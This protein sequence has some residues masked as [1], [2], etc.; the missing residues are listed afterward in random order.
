MS[1]TDT[2]RELS[3]GQTVYDADGNELGHIQG[4]DEHG[5]F[6]NVE[7]GIEGYS[8]RH[9]VS[10][11]E[12]GEAELMWRCLNCGE[13]GDIGQDLPEA[14]PSCGAAKEEIYYWTED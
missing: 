9:V 10:G 4:F 8:V 12:F 11:H 13:M 2:D 3:F 7:H 6:V 1:E 14:C 5:F